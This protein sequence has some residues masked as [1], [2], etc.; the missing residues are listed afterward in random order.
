MH[1]RVRARVRVRVR[2]PVHVRVRVCVLRVSQG[3]YSVRPW[4]RQIAVHFAWY[5]PE[6]LA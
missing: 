2:V 3:A 5:L 6:N 4:L 1:V